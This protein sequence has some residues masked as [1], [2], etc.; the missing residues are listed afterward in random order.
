MRARAPS[1]ETRVRTP[2]AA[3]PNGVLFFCNPS[4]DRREMLTVR[5]SDDEGHTWSKALCLEQ[6]AS[7]YSAMQVLTAPL[8]ASAAFSL[9]MCPARLT[10]RPRSVPQLTHDGCLGVLYERGESRAAF[11]AQRIVFERLLI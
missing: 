9:V 2:V 3:G 7:A 6:G 10:S 5:R 8:E 1:Q 11:F 4:S